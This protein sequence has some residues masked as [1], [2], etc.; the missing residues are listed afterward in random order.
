SEYAKLFGVSL[1]LWGAAGHL[2]LALWLIAYLRGG[3]PVYL[4][5]AGALAGFN[6]VASAVTLYLA[7]VKLGAF[8]LYCT[9]LQG[10]AVA[11]FA[12][13][14]L[15]L[16]RAP[17]RA[18]AWPPAWTGALLALLVVGLAF[19]GEASAARNAERGRLHLDAEG[20]AVRVD[21]SDVITLGNPGTRHTVLIYFD[22]S[23]PVCRGCYFKA[24]ELQRR[25]R[26][27]VHFLFKHFP[28]EKDCNSALSG[29]SNPGSCSAA[30]AGTAALMHNRGLDAMAYFFGER[31]GGFTEFFYEDFCEKFGLD[32]AAFVR[33]R[34]SAE[35][36]ALVQ[37]DIAEGNAM[38]FSRVPMIYLNGRSIA[39]AYLAQRVERACTER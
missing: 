25:F 9:I 30:H 39:P 35:V 36:S 15:G 2:I 4:W 17:R 21:V 7:A 37:R 38:D 32:E 20:E 22:F 10:T 14:A 29:T 1:S 24:I 11:I 31:R 34:E 6:L 13:M 5:G 8:C 18:W 16:R 28:L 33:T 27:D 3:A 26:E 23:C 12:L 19:A